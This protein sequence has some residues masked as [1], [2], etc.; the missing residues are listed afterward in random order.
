MHGRSHCPVKHRRGGTLLHVCLPLAV[1]CVQVTGEV[2]G[3]RVGVVKEGL[4][5]CEAEVS[6]AT[7]NAAEALRSAGAVVEE[8]SIAMHRD[9]ESDTPQVEGSPGPASFVV[10]LVGVM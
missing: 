3:L 1:R 9:S 5:N 7:I 2:R 10:C 6:A 4:E 8:V